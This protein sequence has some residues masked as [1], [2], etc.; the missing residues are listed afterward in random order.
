MKASSFDNNNRVHLED[1]VEASIIVGAMNVNIEN[2]MHEDS[3]NESE[4]DLEYY[5]VKV[6]DTDDGMEDGDFSFDD[7]EDN[8]ARKNLRWA[9]THDDNQATSVWKMILATGKEKAKDSKRRINKG[10]ATIT[11]PSQHKLATKCEEI[12]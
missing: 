4:E 3:D 5:L 11:K 12:E 2:D 9:R 8:Q 7:E 6:A 1:I 10:V